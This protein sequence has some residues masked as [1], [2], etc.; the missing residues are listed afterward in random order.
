ME[1]STPARLMFPV[2]LIAT[3]GLHQ[4]L[5]YNPAAHG[6]PI[7]SWSQVLSLGV[8]GIAGALLSGLDPQSPARLAAASLIAATVYNLNI[9]LVRFALA[10]TYGPAIM[11]PMLA[12]RFVAAF[13]CA[14]L[15]C[16]L[17]RVGPAIAKT[18]KKWWKAKPW[19]QE[20]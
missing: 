8:A 10:A 19:N 20:L 13:A 1:S 11:V 5:W 4:W 18:I 16:L 12:E 6:Q 9:W 7:L 3:F 17:V 15:A 14:L 2:W